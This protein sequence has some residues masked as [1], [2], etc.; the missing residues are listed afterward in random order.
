M[1]HPEFLRSASSPI[2][3]RR[4][5][6]LLWE[7]GKGFSGVGERHPRD[8]SSPSEVDTEVQEYSCTSSLFY[9]T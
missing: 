1:S 8:G 2:K 5:E 3:K 4:P 9:G 6:V 7:E